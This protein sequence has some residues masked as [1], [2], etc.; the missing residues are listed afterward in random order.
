MV[1]SPQFDDVGDFSEGLVRVQD[2]SDDFLW[3]YADKTGKVVI[4]YQ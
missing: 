4:P 1:I 3:G 2:R